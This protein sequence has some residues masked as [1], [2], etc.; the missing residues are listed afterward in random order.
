M[1]RKNFTTLTSEEFTTL[2]VAL[3]QLWD[4]GLI[5]ANAQLHDDNFLNGI[6]WGPAFL[7]WHRDFLRKLELALQDVDATISL[8]Y[9]DWTR[10]GSAPSC[11]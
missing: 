10:T 2:S 7:P 11:R 9:W 4:D 5:E 6:H 1:I 8:P 3:N